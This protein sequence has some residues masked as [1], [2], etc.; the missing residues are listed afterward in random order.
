MDTMPVTTLRERRAPINPVVDAALHTPAGE[1]L[2]ALLRLRPRIGAEALAERVRQRATVLARRQRARTAALLETRE[3]LILRL[4]AEAAPR[5]WFA[6]WCDGSVRTTPTRRIAGIGGVVLD[7][8]GHM[9]AEFSRR[10]DGMNAFDAE[11]AALTT[12]LE[13]ALSRHAT[14]LRV[15]TD[16]DALAK[17]WREKRSDPRLAP[18]R[19]HARALDRFELRALPRLHNQAANTLAHAGTR[20]RRQAFPLLRHSSKLRCGEGSP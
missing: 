8:E 13:V 10:A 16:C 17:L 20:I 14:R 1:P 11:I 5:G 2:A 4:Y 19:M 3:V 18:V 9:A 15:H 6:A 7:P 12:T